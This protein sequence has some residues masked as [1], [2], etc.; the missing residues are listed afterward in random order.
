MAKANLEYVKLACAE[1]G[2]EPR[3]NLCIAITA[4][5]WP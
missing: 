3:R 2:P 4:L 1:A 5:E